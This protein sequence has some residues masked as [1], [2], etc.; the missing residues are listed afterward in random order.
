MFA[1]VVTSVAGCALQH[2]EVLG[3][4]T[5]IMW[6]KFMPD[7]EVWNLFKIIQIVIVSWLFPLRTST[8]WMPSIVYTGGPKWPQLSE[9]KC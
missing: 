7:K 9:L 5:Y 4:F 3:I 1:S 6:Q 2:S 8:T